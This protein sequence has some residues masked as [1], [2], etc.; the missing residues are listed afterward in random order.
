VTLVLL[1]PIGLD[2]GCWE[3]MALA[4]DSV[5]KHTFPGFGGRERARE[6]PTMASL[7]DEVA[8]SYEPPLDLVGVSLGGMVAQHVTIVCCTGANADPATMHARAEAAERDG[9]AGV[10]QET[11]ERW[12]TPGFLASQPEH[13][14]VAY[15]R[16]TLLALDPACFADG[17]RAIAGHDAR[18]HLAQIAVPT[19]ALAG[20][21]DAA[22][23]ISRSREIADRVPGGRFVE[24]DGPHMMQLEHP[25]EL[26]REIAEH[27]S[28]AARSA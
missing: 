5:A 2:A 10:L 22:S 24:I 4:H 16:R 26:D 17:W 11:L 1:T 19:T 9:M 12:F 13:P 3:G 25:L 28:W 7:A 27:L 15:A 8:A 23:A 21:S 18:E 14:G 6:Q 20:S